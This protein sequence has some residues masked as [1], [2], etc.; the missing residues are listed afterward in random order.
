MTWA[1]LPILTDDAWSILLLLPPL[2]H[3]L[4]L[5]PC[6][7][8]LTGDDSSTCSSHPPHQHPQQRINPSQC[9]QSSTRHPLKLRLSI[10]TINIFINNNNP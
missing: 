3:D 4:L 5:R 10:T 7:S 2:L 1:S 6:R 9:L 8:C